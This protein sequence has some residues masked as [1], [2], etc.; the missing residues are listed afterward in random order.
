MCITSEL[1]NGNESASNDARTERIQG[2]EERNKVGD[3]AVQT[4][5]KRATRAMS[6]LHKDETLTWI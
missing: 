6:R 1:M 3:P 4:F 5:E 2:H